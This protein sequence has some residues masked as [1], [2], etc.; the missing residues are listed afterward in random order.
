M[1]FPALNCLQVL[2]YHFVESVVSLDQFSDGLKLPTL[3][4]QVIHLRIT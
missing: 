2:A 4:T 3:L 1:N